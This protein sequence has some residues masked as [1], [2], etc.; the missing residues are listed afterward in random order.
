[1]VQTATIFTFSPAQESK[2]WLCKLDFPFLT[3][4]RMQA[5]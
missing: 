1:M 5:E 2:N 3:V 4:N